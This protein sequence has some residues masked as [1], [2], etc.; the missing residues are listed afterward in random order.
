M[1]NNNRKKGDKKVE[2]YLENAR[3]SDGTNTSLSILKR[4]GRR[5]LLIGNFR[6]AER[7]L[8]IAL[9]KKPEDTS[10]KML[11]GQTYYRS[12][13]LTKALEIFE[14][15]PKTPEVL[16]HI[17]KIYAFR[18][19]WDESLE[20]FEKL[21]TESQKSGDISWVT[22]AESEIKIIKGADTAEFK[23]LDP[24]IQG[25]IKSAP[26]QSKFPEAGAVVLLRENV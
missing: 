14:R 6:E 17:G 16:Y 7:V 4:L 23:D 26:S 2:M 9:Q 3:N 5:F 11:L 20:Y 12:G 1:I 25:I 8:K 10:S 24:H 22:L 21:K 19:C 15:L 18:E 13:Q